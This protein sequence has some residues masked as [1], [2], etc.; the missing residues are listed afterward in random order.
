MI[1]MVNGYPTEQELRERIERQ[2]ARRGATDTVAL[3][4]HGYLTGLLEWGVIELDVFDRLSALLPAIGHL[5]LVELSID[6][7]ATLEL[8][9]E[10]TESMRAKKERK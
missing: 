10:I 9:R 2:I 7:Q 3:I 8:E 1:C 6:E 4:W 5:E